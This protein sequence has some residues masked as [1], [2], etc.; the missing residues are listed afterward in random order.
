MRASALHLGLAACLAASVA[1]CASEVP[2]EKLCRGTDTACT[3][4]P[5][6]CDLSATNT[7]AVVVRWRI[8]DAALGRLLTRGQCCCNPDPNPGPLAREQCPTT[9]GDACLESP[10]WM[11]RD[12]KL[13]VS[14]AGAPEEWC[15][16]TAGCADGELTT[17]ACLVPGEYDL[18]LIADVE[19]FLA[20]APG[21]PVDRSEFQCLNRPAL[22]PPA[23]RR[24]VRAGQT[25][26]LDGIVLGVN[27]Q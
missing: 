14:R 13:K 15:T 17:P 24:P 20:P 5:A 23:V 18:Q 16:F 8:A 27:G 7:G 10:A 2:G 1:S 21:Q 4:V 22:T 26:N 12:V 9:I 6:L 11:V 19:G 3:A 25:V